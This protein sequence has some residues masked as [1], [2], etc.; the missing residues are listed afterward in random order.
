MLH[1]DRQRVPAFAQRRQR[2]GGDVEAE[3]QILPE[4]LLRDRRL[5]IHIGGGD[6]AHIHLG[7]GAG[8]ESGHLALLQHAQQLDLQSQGQV[9]DF[10]QQQRAAASRLEPAAPLGTHRTRKGALFMAE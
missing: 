8:A 9:A 10:I 7:R 6:H 1:Q 4:A 3:I 5:Q 2:D